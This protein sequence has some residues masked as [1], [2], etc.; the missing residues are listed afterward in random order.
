MPLDAPQCGW[1]SNRII[2]AGAL[3]PLLKIVQ[4]QT[5]IVQ[6]PTKNVQQV[7]EVFFLR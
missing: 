1:I 3:A 6:K 5:K 7:C 2:S 4:K